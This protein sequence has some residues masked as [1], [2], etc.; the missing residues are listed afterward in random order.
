M[1]KKN[2][3]GLARSMFGD[4][5]VQEEELQE[6]APEIQEEDPE[7]PG[8]EIQEMEKPVRQSKKKMAD[9]YTRQTYW[10]RNDFIKTIADY[11]YT[12]RI[13]IR[14]AVNKLIELGLDQVKEDYEAENKT[15]MEYKKGD[16]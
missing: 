7:L 16:F 13:N 5:S 6:P 9:L 2:P 4:I 8:Q 15:M 12:E 10:I 3:F 14:Q 1:A 11:A